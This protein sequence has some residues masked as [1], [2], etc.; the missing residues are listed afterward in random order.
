[1]TRRRYRFPFLAWLLIVTSPY[2]AAR[3]CFAQALIV[4]TMIVDGVVRDSSGAVIRGAAVHLE[5]GSFRAATKTDGRGRFSFADVP[6]GAGTAAVSAEGFVTARKTWG[7]EEKNRAGKNEEKAGGGNRAV[8]LEIVLEP[9]SVREQV[10]VSAARTEVRLS[11]TPGST[12]LLSTA[13]VTAAPA[14]RVDDVLRE[15]PGFSLFRRSGSRT[16]NP[17]SQGVSLR[18]LGGTAAS[19]ALVLAD[20]ISLVDPFGG[21]VDW[22][23]LPRAAISTVEVV[24]GGASNL[25]GS[26]AMG[27]VVQFLMRHP[28]APAF[29][30]ETSYGNGRTPDLSFWTGSRAGRWDYSLATEMFRT[31]GFILVPDSVRGSVD[32]PANS[33]NATVYAR[34]GHGLGA[35]GKIFGRGNYYTDSRNNGTRIQ[36]NDT[37]LGEGAGGLDKQ[38]GA[39]DSLSVRI[40]GQVESYHQKYSA[41]ASDRNSET[42]TDIQHV[43]EQAVGGG[44]QWTHLLGKSQTLIGG[45]DLSEVMGASEDLLLTGPN[46][47]QMGAGRQRTLGWFGED[48]FHRPKWT[49]ILGARV[50]DWSNFDGRVITVP[51]SG[52]PVATF[53]SS[54]GD[55]AFSP[56]LS[57]LRSVNEH[58]S[59]TGSV[60]R[61]FRAPTLNELYRTFRVG[62]VKTYNNPF[63]NAERLTGAEA[64]VNV[65]GW[66]RKVDL[67]GTFFWSD[68]VDP[69]ENVTISTTPTLITDQKENLGRTRSRGVEL[70][71]VVHVNRDIQITAGYAYTAATVVSYPGN[72]GGID[73]VGLD[74]PQ[75]PRNVFTWEARYW[76]LSRFLLSVDG[77]FVSRQFDDDQNQYP[78][79]G[80][81]TMDLELGCSLTRHLELFAAAENLLNQRYQ[82]ARTPV[83]SLGP[84]ILFRVGLRVN[85]PAG[86]Q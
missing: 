61:A 46:Q 16:A 34:I 28:E 5:S 10:V 40:Y 66:D 44:A 84:P 54:R 36:A 67:R 39:N 32:T 21:W 56:R 3:D 83:V 63:L 42:L 75:V 23:R 11:D 82:V 1:M 22:N 50:D 73:L 19:R 14:L 43:P 48:I 52:P 79:N 7:Q 81:Y 78:L 41:V 86:K 20:G 37:Q 8:H 4:R 53:Y 13:D 24:R 2:F 65:T 17:S 71:G 77:R 27:G 68:I 47:S 55:V 9:S 15:V 60:Y 58:V 38:F 31:D 72:P 30:L 49:V 62:N 64:G 25:Y 57:V 69:I 6:Q 70:D 35:N 26:D 80:F 85:Y 74:V 76:N 45:M 12:I 33:E 18:G 59:V 29:A 51:V